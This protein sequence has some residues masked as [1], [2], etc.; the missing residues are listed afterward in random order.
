MDSEFNELMIDDSNDDIIDEGAEYS[1]KS[2]FNKAKQVDDAVRRC[3]EARGH[4]MI[5]GFW[6][7]KLARDGQPIREWK[8]DSRKV[9]IGTIEALRA[10]LNPEVRRDEKFKKIEKQIL[11]KKAGLYK[12]Y[13]YDEW[14]LTTKDKGEGLGTVAIFKKTSRSY[15]PDIGA[16]VNI[17]ENIYSTQVMTIKGGW[18]ENV[19]AYWDNLLILYDKMFASLMDLC[20]RN[21]YFKQA[22]TYG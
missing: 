7:T 18:D 12:I 15:M 19:N 17:R 21:N 9:F 1:P 8:A 22:L 5:A 6:N 20:D 3:I 11:E 4:E 13:K 16:T 14:A 10:L 2:D